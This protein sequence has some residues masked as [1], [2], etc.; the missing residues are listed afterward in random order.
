[1]LERNQ[2]DK[3]TNSMHDGNR[4]VRRFLH[5]KNISVDV[6]D[7]DLP[8]CE[9]LGLLFRLEGYS[10]RFE[11]SLEELDRHPEAHAADVLV[12]SMSLVAGAGLAGTIRRLRNPPSGGSRCVVL[13]AEAGHDIGE[14][15]EAMR[16]GAAAVVKRPVDK[17]A[18]L[19]LVS[20]ELGRK[21]RHE[22][23]SDGHEH[24]VI[25]G[26]NQLTPRE[27]EI[28]NRIVDGCSNKEIAR[29]LDISPR[30]VEVHRSAAMHKLGAK[31]T[32]EL[33]KI[34]LTV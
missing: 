29:E 28:V 18:L 3:L 1:M 13:L 26:V 6:V 17:E 25:A 21:I 34:V 19:Q 30:T 7:A 22:I 11:T 14:V 4:F 8:T 27:R 31:N 16:A 12:V 2:S 15:V 20:E 32:A 24:I 23:G 9:T 10:T 5:N 33:V